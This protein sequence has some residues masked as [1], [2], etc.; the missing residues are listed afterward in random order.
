MQTHQEIA[1]RFQNE[2]GIEVGEVHGLTRLTLRSG[3]A[4][5]ELYCQGAHVT[6]AVRSDGTP[7]LFLSPQSQ[8]KSG[9]A[10]R[11]GIPLIFPW[12]GPDGQN[13]A[14][15]QHGFV[16][17]AI[18]RVEALH[19]AE[20]EPL[21]ALLTFHDDETT[22][23]WRPFAFTATY[24]VEL[25]D[26]LTLTLAIR[27]DWSEP[28]RFEEAFHTY[29]PVSDIRTARIQGLGGASFI[30][31]TDSLRRKSLPDGDLIL[32][33]ETDSVF[34]GSQATVRIV[35]PASPQTMVVDKQNSASTIVWNPWA[36]KGSSLSDL[37][38]AWERM[39]CVESAN[40]GADSVT[41]APGETHVMQSTIRV[42]TPSPK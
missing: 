8:F 11:G 40:A 27:N 37:G 16:R 18:W 2:K 41:V 1:G 30:D 24:R 4:M 15:P 3:A 22:H 12:F 14:N 25:A 42:Q 13:P 29:L 17:T 31:K 5:L 36:E 10:I 6:Q 38:A 32:E 34:E 9:K 28:F 26:A 19:A 21:I 33:R 39:I 35:D 7:L 20:G 23:A